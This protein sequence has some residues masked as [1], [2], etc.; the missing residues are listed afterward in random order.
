VFGFQNIS[1]MGVIL[2][3]SIWLEA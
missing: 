1:G 2:F 3:L